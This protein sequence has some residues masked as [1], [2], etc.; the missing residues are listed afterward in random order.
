MLL[1]G[2]C[3]SKGGVGI[4]RDGVFVVTGSD[5]NEAIAADTKITGA[6][7]SVPEVFVFSRGNLVGRIQ[8][9]A[10]GSGDII[11]ALYTPEK[12]Q[13]YDWRDL[14]GGYWKRWREAKPN[15]SLPTTPA[16]QKPLVP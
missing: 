6:D 5:R 1:G 12:V 13:F 15:A 9:P 2:Q 4:I 16:G 11:L 8:V 3:V 10:G 7:S 14:T